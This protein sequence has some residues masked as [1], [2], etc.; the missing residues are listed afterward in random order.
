MKESDSYKDVQGR[1]WRM[2]ES[3]CLHTMGAMGAKWSGG[4]VAWNCL[5]AHRDY[6]P[7][8]HGSF[9]CSTR[10]N[11]HTRLS[12]TSAFAEKFLGLVS[13]LLLATHPL[14]FSFLADPIV[15]P[16]V[17]IQPLPIL[18]L[19]VYRV[20]SIPPREK[21]PQVWRNAMWHPVSG[22]VVSPSSRMLPSTVV[23]DPQSKRPED[24]MKP[25]L[26]QD[27][28]I[29]LAFY[30]RRLIHRGALFSVLAVSRETLSTSIRVTGSSK[31]PRYVL[32]PAIQVR[33][34]TL[35]SPLLTVV[36]TLYDT[37]PS[38]ALFPGVTFPRWPH[39]YGCEDSHNTK[40]LAFHCAKKSLAAFSTLVAFATF[41]FSLWLT[42]YADDCFAE[43]FTVLAERNREKLPRV[44]LEY[45]KDS[46]ICTLSPGLRP[47][48]FL[49]PYV[50]RWGPFIR[51]FTRA[52][53]P[54][55]ILWGKDEFKKQNL[56]D[57]GM[58]YYFPPPEFVKVAKERCLTFSNTILPYE[59]TY[60]FAGGDSNLPASGPM[61]DDASFLPTDESNSN[62]AFAPDGFDFDNG[63]A[64][65]GRDEFRDESNKSPPAPVVDR[66][67]CVHAG[68]GQQP[69]ES[70]EAFHARET[71]RYEKRKRQETAQQKQTRENLEKAAERGPTNK[72]AVF[73]WEQDEHVPTFYRRTRVIKHDAVCEWEGCTP[74]QRFFWGHRNEWDLCPHLPAYP[75]GVPAPAAQDYLDSDDEDAPILKYYSAP[76]PVDEPIGPIIQRAV[77]LLTERDRNLED[78]TYSFTFSKALDYLRLRH[79]FA[80]ANF[81]TSWNPTLHT[82]PK[83]TL[84]QS[85]VD[86]ALKNLGYIAGDTV[87]NPSPLS[88]IVDFHNTAM[89]RTLSYGAL[90]AAWDISRHPQSSLSCDLKRI[91][92]QRIQS[93]LVN[94]VDVYV[95]QPPRGS[96]DRSSW[97]IATTSAT[98]VLM[99]YRSQ[100]NTM[101]E[102]A[103]GLLD[104]GVPFHT[105]VE[106]DR[107][108]RDMAVRSRTFGLGPRPPK[109]QPERADFAAYEN[110]RDDILR[111]RS[112][113]AIRLLG[114]IV[115]RLAV[116]LVPDY[117]VLD[118]PY[119][120]NPVVV[121]THG[122]KEFVDDAVEQRELDVVCGVYLVEGVLMETGSQM[123]WWPKHTT[124]QLTAFAGDQWLPRAEEWYK[125][126]RDEL[127]SGKL[128]LLA[129]RKWDQSLKFN[130]AQ[131]LELRKGTER[132]AAE[133]IAN[134]SRI[135]I[136]S[137]VPRAS[138]TSHTHLIHAVLRASHMGCL[139]HIIY[140]VLRAS[141]TPH[142]HLIHEVLR[143]SHMGCLSH[144]IYEVL[145]ASETP[146]THL[147][148]EVLRASH[149]GCLS[150]IIYEVLQASH[151]IHE[152]LRASHMGCLSH[153]IYEVLRA[154]HLIHESHRATDRFR[155]WEVI[156][157]RTERFDFLVKWRR[158]ISYPRILQKHSRNK[159]HSA[160]VSRENV[161]HRTQIKGEGVEEGSGK[162]TDPVVTYDIVDERVTLYK[163]KG[164]SLADVIA[165]EVLPL[166]TATEATIMKLFSAADRLKS[167][168]TKAVKDMDDAMKLLNVMDK[169]G[170]EVTYENEAEKAMAKMA[171]DS[172]YP[173]YEEF[174]AALPKDSADA[175]LWTEDEWKL[176]LKTNEIGN[177]TYK[178]D[179]DKKMVEMA[180]N[181]FYPAFKE[182]EEALGKEVMSEEDWKAYLQLN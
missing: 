114:G 182:A 72:S 164:M 60:Q 43:A 68:S 142:T 90:P 6:L 65:S 133:F 10:S 175:F 150:H 145:R 146:H 132:M 14:R 95:L 122:D 66:E 108:P 136:S 163:P 71:E 70:W 130:A 48:G 62:T 120:T 176:Y 40:E 140:E 101:G 92:L 100:W 141:E 166:P 158:V 105:V 17:P 21:L 29:Y 16:S 36:H 123:S 177:I 50:T 37:H 84:S 88:S 86:L 154:S 56:L 147:I 103:Q 96:Q 41:V 24:L 76:K 113:R 82:H 129:A 151:L 143:A 32:D 33:W 4:T 124:F 31:S 8:L 102:I 51:L 160:L 9:A 59:H 85:K 110:A 155:L 181:A 98:A 19:L 127:R 35:E 42:E 87:L 23:S 106:R 28:D 162:V 156:K 128:T 125:K 149:M 12:S 126:R 78:S 64:F 116:D 25:R 117:E 97:F 81:P 1:R 2:Q 144:I 134:S 26:L 53:V 75:P 165:Q 161:T 121:G 44:W 47:G 69:R 152:V 49:N 58:G 148:H 27:E 139:S 118:G 131:V 171:F 104:R 39:Q 173:K 67:L 170:D 52:S 112:G 167:R 63:H 54:F 115:G 11:S 168:R 73:L 7:H 80:A 119:L 89:N 15:H 94:N 20:H 135:T 91:K 46:V 5:G 138:E 74:H 157:Q 169:K 13:L 178:D 77:E 79:G 179:A 93:A 174:K 153:I 18:I 45:L 180:F 38:K 99:V 61:F 3:D 159:S 22:L 107:Q 30:P 57:P 111:S 83:Y 109:F 34:K 55:W 172:F 137:E